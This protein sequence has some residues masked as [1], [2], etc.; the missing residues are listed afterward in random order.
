MNDLM[1]GRFNS[2]EEKIDQYFNDYYSDFNFCRFFFFDETIV[3]KRTGSI[4]I[5]RI[6]HFSSQLLSSQIYFGQ[7]FQ[8]STSPLC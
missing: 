5:Y 7:K 4:I 1:R 2:V 3:K 6:L 8:T